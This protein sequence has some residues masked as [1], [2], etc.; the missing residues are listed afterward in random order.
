MFISDLLRLF[1]LSDFD[2]LAQALAMEPGDSGLAVLTALACFNTLVQMVLRKFI[3]W[4]S[5]A[6]TG[7]FMLHQVVHLAGGE[8]MGVR[9]LLDFTHHASGVWA[10]WAARRWAN[11]ANTVNAGPREA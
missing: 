10:C 3:F 5:V 8:E 2:A 1:M 9:S 11:T 4:A 7:F 6:Y